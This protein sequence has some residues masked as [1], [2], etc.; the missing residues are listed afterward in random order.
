M[1]TNR[2]RSTRTSRSRRSSNLQSTAVRV[3]PTP[4][5]E[6]EAA[7]PASSAN[8]DWSREYAYV[9]KDLRQLS[10]VSVALLVLMLVV[11]FFI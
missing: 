6:T 5:E 9:V 8:V 10:V 3:Y 4:G 7:T 11:G 2:K 1:A